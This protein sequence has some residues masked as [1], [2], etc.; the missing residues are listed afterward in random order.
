M[1][2]ALIASPFI[3]VPPRL[4]G[5]TELFIA[6][7]AL[8]LQARGYDPT[9]YSNGDSKITVENKYFYKDME[10]PLISDV[11][12]Q[13]KDAHHTAWAIKD[14]SISCDVIHLNNSVG[15]S[16]SHFVNKP[17]V[18]TVHHKKVDALS[19]YYGHYP[20]ID[21]AMISDAQRDLEVMPRRVTIHHGI[22]MSLYQFVKKKQNYLAFLGRICPIKGTHLAIDVAHKSG[23]P[24]KI[25]GEIQP[26]FQEY[27]DTQIRPHVDGR[28]IE[29]IGPVNLAAK[30]ELL[31]NAKALLFPIQWDEPFGL[32]MIEAMACGTPV[33][34]L[35]GGSVKE[36]VKNKVSGTVCSSVDELVTA[37]ESIDI[38]SVDIRGYAESMF[39]VDT[40]VDQYIQ[41]YERLDF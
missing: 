38:D 24:L 14:A 22:D 4:Y 18:Y 2:I 3:P 25:A 30:T 34:A 9:V 17:F 23:I 13:F 6:N 16:Y 5:G 11:H 33:I 31:G 36:I 32:V 10:W 29:Y 26:M 8:G 27:F 41:L 37:A 19:E 20:N 1:R 15:L 39:S 21:Y 35:K 40:M 12:A 28:F 7:L